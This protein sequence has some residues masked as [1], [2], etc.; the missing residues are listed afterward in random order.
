MRKGGRLDKTVKMEDLA[1]DASDLIRGTIGGWRG[2][3]VSSPYRFACGRDHQPCLQSK[4]LCLGEVER[5]F[6][7]A[8][9]HV[10]LEE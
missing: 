3:S 8:E 1:N 6:P 5:F 9:V 2:A 4:V 7:H 10:R